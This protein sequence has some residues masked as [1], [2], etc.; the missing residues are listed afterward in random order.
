M[1]RAFELGPIRSV[2]V[3]VRDMARSRTFFRDALG[4]EETFA[5]DWVTQFKAGAVELVIEPV[6][7]ADP[8]GAEML[9]RYTGVMFATPDAQAVY[10]GLRARGVVFEA[11]PEKMF[12]GATF[13]HFRDPDGNIFTACQYPN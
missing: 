9:G 12:W 1:T 6:D 10:D 13:A 8:E 11:P 5:N 4:L 2:R 7:E 3:A